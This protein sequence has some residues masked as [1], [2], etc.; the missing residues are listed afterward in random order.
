M[1]PNPY[2]STLQALGGEG[3][4]GTL[5]S[6]STF[7]FY[8]RYWCPDPI[9]QFRSS[10]ELH[11]WRFYMQLLVEE[12]RLKRA[13]ARMMNASCL[14]RLRYDSWCP[15]LLLRHDLKPRS[16]CSR[17]GRGVCFSRMGVSVSRCSECLEVTLQVCARCNNLVRYFQQ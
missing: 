2:P 13:K 3:G 16:P 15:K 5:S 11:P 6:T 8:Y 1:I 14:W 9:L 4:I 10:S 12:V 7:Y 17:Y